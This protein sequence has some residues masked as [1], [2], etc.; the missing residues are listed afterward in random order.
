MA[1]TLTI[2]QQPSLVLMSPQHKP[3]KDGK[4]P[5]PATAPNTKRKQSKSR[6][7]IAVHILSTISIR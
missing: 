6:N 1:E 4:P 2:P 3:L 5:L 7:G